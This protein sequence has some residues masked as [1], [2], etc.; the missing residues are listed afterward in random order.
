MPTNVKNGF[1][2]DDWAFDGHQMLKG[3]LFRFIGE[4]YVHGR[5]SSSFYED[6]SARL[7]EMEVFNLC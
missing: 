6:K 1:E 3:S 5:M 4:C 2:G 7:G